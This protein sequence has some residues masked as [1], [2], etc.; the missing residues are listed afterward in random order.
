MD[1]ATLSFFE[2]LPVAQ[3]PTAMLVRE[4]IVSAFPQVAEAIKWNQLTFHYGNIN[5][6]FIYSP[7]NGGLR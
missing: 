3:K 1:A 7:S 5:L 6:A 2:K 4:C